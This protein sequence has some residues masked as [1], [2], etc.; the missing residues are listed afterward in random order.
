MLNRNQHLRFAPDKHG[1]LQAVISAI[2][3]APHDHDDGN[4]TALAAFIVF[5]LCIRA[6]FVSVNTDTEFQ[7][8]PV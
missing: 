5:K 7:D 8:S 6:L 3:F 4:S 2:L 1:R